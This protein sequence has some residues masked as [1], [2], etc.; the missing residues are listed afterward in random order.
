MR[1]I[2]Y[3]YITTYFLIDVLATVPCIITEEKNL[4][5]YPFK[6]LRVGRITRIVEL[7]K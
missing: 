2:A 4:N 5:Y 1:I 7:S 6:L 3:N